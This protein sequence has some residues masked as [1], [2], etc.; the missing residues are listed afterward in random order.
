M[1]A[2]RIQSPVAAL[3]CPSKHVDLSVFAQAIF[4][5]MTGNDYFPSPDPALS[6]LAANIVAFNQALAAALNRTKGAA[7]ARDA[8]RQRLVATLRHLRD[9]VQRIVELLATDND[10]AAAIITSAGMSVR[11]RY[12]R[13]KAQFS[14]TQGK[15]PGTAVL[16]A[17][18]AVG[19]AVYFWEYSVDQITWVTVPET[20]KATADI[21]GLASH[22]TYYFRFR[23]RTRT[24]L[25]DYSQVVSLFVM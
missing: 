15:L 14:A 1:T 23:V 17:R 18:A 22:Q 9:Y 3:K 24:G 21:A 12:K 6:V 13:Y 5:A 16:S 20:L 2:P 25:G 4:N 8:E 19:S 10:M 7:E 11:R